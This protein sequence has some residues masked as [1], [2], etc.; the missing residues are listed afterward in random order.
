MERDLS[1]RNLAQVT[2]ED[3]LLKLLNVI[4]SEM[5]GNNTHPFYG[6]Q[7]LMFRYDGRNRNYKTFSIPKK[8]GGFRDINSPRGNLKWMQLCL[9]EIFKTLYTP[10][11]NVMGFTAGKSIV[12]N[13][14]AHLSKEYVFNIDLYSFFSYVDD[15]MIITLKIEESSLDCQ[16]TGLCPFM[17]RWVLKKHG[18]LIN[19]LFELKKYLYSVN[20]SLISTEI[21]PD[22]NPNQ[23]ILCTI[24]FTVLW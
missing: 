18:W 23:K 24:T 12:D 11:P 16:P 14:K 20:N 10:C 4:K 9:N 3:T 22:P 17:C 2:D 5:L 1:I 13:A 21:K 7:M 15:R 19:E 8:A 6:A